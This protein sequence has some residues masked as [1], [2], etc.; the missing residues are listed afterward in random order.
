[1]Y[2]CLCARLC[3]LAGAHTRCGKLHIFIEFLSTHDFAQR[4]PASYKPKQPCLAI[5]I[6]ILDAVNYKKGRT[7]PGL[8]YMIDNTH[9]PIVRVGA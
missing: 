8:P 4:I 6:Y 1:M 5:L 7:N 3:A 9:F 2:V